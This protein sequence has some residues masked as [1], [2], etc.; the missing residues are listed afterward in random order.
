MQLAHE[1]AG[2]GLVLDAPA[3]TELP[4]VCEVWPEHLDALNLWLTCQPQL[5]LVV[6][7]GGSLWLAARST[8]VAQ[9]A[10]W[11]GLAVQRQGDVVAQ[12]RVIEAEALRIL[13]TL[14]K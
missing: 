6:G 13:N 10:Q 5:R 2:L 12:Y 9:E 3:P 11:L 14:N 8:D 7:M 4:E 1:L